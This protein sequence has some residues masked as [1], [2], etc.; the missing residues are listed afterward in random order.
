MEFLLNIAL[1]GSMS[2]VSKYVK[3]NT[4]DD[5]AQGGKNGKYAGFM[6]IGPSL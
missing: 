3:G 5:A 4:V 1:H 2:V 6:K